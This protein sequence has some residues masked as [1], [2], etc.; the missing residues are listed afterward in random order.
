MSDGVRRRHLLKRAS[1]GVLAGIG[2]SN[3]VAAKRNDRSQPANVDTNQ[4][5]ETTAGWNQLAKLA[6]DDGSR[7]DQ[8]GLSVATSGDGTSAIVGAPNDE[9]GSA[10]VFT[11]S[12]E[13]WEQQAKLVADDVDGGDEFGS[14]VDISKDG[15]TAIIGA[16]SD[17]DPNG[18]SAGSAYVFSSAGGDWDQQ[19]KIV[20][21]DGDSD[22]LFGWSV[23]LSD[24]GTVAIIGAHNDDDPN[25]TTGDEDDT[26]GGAGSAYVFSRTDESWNQQSKIFAEDGDPD[27]NFGA[28]V[29]ISGDGTT[30][31]VGANVDEDPN[32]PSAGSAYVFSSSG[33]NWEQQDKLTAEDGDSSDNFGISLDIDANGTTALIGA[34]L[35]ENLN[36]ELAGSGYVFASSGGNWTQQTKL[37]A[38]DGG[39]FDRFGISVSISGDGTTA[40]VGSYGDPESPGIAY[41][42]SSA[43]EN[44]EQQAKFNAADGDSDD[45][46]GSYISLSDDG[47]VAIVGAYEDSDANGYRSGSAYVFGTSESDSDRIQVPGASGPAKDIDG[48]T[49]LE[50]VNGDGDSD[51]FDALSYYN[52]RN[53]QAIQSNPDKFDFDGDGTAGT[54]FDALQ[55]YNEIS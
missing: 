36:G 1:I 54:L 52:N 47:S 16:R 30:A 41:A 23:D 20:A 43:G 34:G 22:D 35:D 53:S 4:I 18:P 42:F 31:L 5:I 29:S 46:F 17:E 9:G 38:D 37:L 15:T 19:A 26:Y 48:D 39:S 12:S 27:D 50:D 10:Y 21:E 25:G 49:L 51:L 7:L 55:L 8:F 28:S 14:S 40:V 24:D 33:G 44:W 13:G 11:P 45:S 2:S 3:A 32:G 6:A